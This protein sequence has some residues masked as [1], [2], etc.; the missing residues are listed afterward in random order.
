LITTAVLKFQSDFHVT[1]TFRRIWATT[2]AYNLFEG[3]T[4]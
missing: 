4:V 3:K 1:L 2:C